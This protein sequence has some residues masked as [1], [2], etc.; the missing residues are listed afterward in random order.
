[1]GDPAFF[2]GARAFLERHRYAKAGTEDLRAALEAASGQDLEPY[3]ENAVV[4]VEWPEAG[5]GA[6]PPARA[7]VRID[8]GGRDRREIELVAT[9]DALLEGIGE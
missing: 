9:D 4:F 6:L 7:A 8:H 5:L 2:S 1:V 3:F